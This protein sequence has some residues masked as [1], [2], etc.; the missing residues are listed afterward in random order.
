MKQLAFIIAVIL[1]TIYQPL[2]F[3]SKTNQLVGGLV[4]SIV[5]IAWYS[6]AYIHA[7]RMHNALQSKTPDEKLNVTIN[8]FYK[9][10]SEKDDA[11]QTIEKQ[12]Q[13]EN[14]LSALESFYFACKIR[15]E[16]APF[17]KVHN[18]KKQ[19][20]IE[21]YLKA[22]EFAVYAKNLNGK[23]VDFPQD[24]FLSLPCFTALWHFR[25]EDEE[26][27]ANISDDC[28]LYC[29]TKADAELIINT[30]QETI[31][32][33]HKIHAERD[34]KVQSI[35]SPE[36]IK[37]NTVNNNQ[38][39]ILVIGLGGM[40]ANAINHL[41]STEK[42]V[43]C[44]ML[45]ADTD[46]QALD[47]S[48]AENTLL[49]GD[50]NKHKGIGAS[51]DKKI[52]KEAAAYSLDKLRSYVQD[53]DKLCLIAGLGGG[54]GSGAIPVI[55]RY[56]HDLGKKVVCIVTLPFVFEGTPASNVAQNTLNELNALE[57][58]NIVIKNQDSMANA[59]N[60]STFADAF[61][62]TNQKIENILR[63]ITHPEHEYNS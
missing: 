25:N 9:M 50:S 13:L 17:F 3:V 35:N 33:L 27:F 4:I 22:D 61:R 46:V 58:Q 62:E 60:N 44:T 59:S 42:L 55:A 51:K 26:V 15:K 57:V 36:N 23:M 63:E 19:E 39:R 48:P 52:G 21:L 32:D 7:A 1:I 18:I 8:S 43:H 11:L 16:H 6:N 47:T 24:A 28:R 54:T 2:S 38:S 37:L 5:L 49:L 20:F 34:K 41:I 56:A 14:K 12:K 31:N 30:M 29:G 10:L 40:G 53:A 45:L